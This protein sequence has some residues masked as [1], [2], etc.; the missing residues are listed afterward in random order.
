MAA[1]TFFSECGAQ[2]NKICHC[3]HCFPIC[4]KVMGLDAM[5][6][7]FWVL[8]FK[9]AFPLSSFTFIKRLWSYSSISALS[10][11]VICISEVIDISP[12]NLNS[13]LWFMQPGIW[14]DVLCEELTHWKRPRCWEGL[15]AGEKGT[16][17]DEMAGWHHR[18]YG[19]EFE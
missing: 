16:T 7:V 15:G 11:V 18:L 19:H 10:V 9:P 14:H 1:V 6:F 3:L 12:D 8:S 17:Q 13:S 4:H 2:E 5:I